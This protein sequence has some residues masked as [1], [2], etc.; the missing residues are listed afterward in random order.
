MQTFN[1]AAG[2][3]DGSFEALTSFPVPS[4]VPT[5]NDINE[6][7]TGLR[8]GDFNHDGKLDIAYSFSDQASDTQIYYEGFAV[9]LGNGDGTFQA[10]KITLTYQGAT[11]PV[12]FPSNMLSGIADVNNDNFPDVFHDRSEYCA[13]CPGARTRPIVRWQWRRHF[14]GAEHTDA[15]AQYSAVDAGWRHWLSVCIRRFE[16][17]REDGHRRQ[18]LIRRRYNAELAI[19]LGNGDGTF[20]PPTILV[21]QGFG[22]P[23]APALANFTGGGKMDL[24]LNGVTE[25]TGMGIFPG[26]GDGTFQTISNG[27]GT[28]SAPQQIVLPVDGG[29]VAVDLNK[30]G[31]PD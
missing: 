22:F 12:V 28:V 5:G 11:A 18:R 6:S 25:G 9:Q 26:N 29:A 21:F 27:D 30:D 10:P 2:V 4:L 15:A 24:Y 14:Q 23:A 19:A 20:M 3:G 17:R 31:E 8:T 16:W 13:E 1:L 7:L